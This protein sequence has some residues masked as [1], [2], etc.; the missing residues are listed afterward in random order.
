MTLLLVAGPPASGKTG[1]AQGLSQR[2]GWPAFCKDAIKEK[3]FDTIGFRSRV[4][5]VALGKGAMEVMCYAAAKVLMAGSS[6]VLESNFEACD[7]PVL[8]DMLAGISGVQAI[9]VRLDAD[10]D[11]LH[12]RFCARD[13]SATRHIGH[14][15][16]DVYPRPEDSA[17]INTQ[18]PAKEAFEAG[19]AA[20]GMRT[21]SLGT[22]IEVDTTNA[23]PTEWDGLVADVYF[24][25]H[26]TMLRA[27]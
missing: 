24:R 26:S 20:R 19:I 6:V 16:N 2:L 3:L 22:L 11:V 1:V 13:T 14:I 4:E 23:K 21:F 12:E 17:S 25:V 15:V 9:T 27:L 7:M 10:T 18:K 5:K 8:L